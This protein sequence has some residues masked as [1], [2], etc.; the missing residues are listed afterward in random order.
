MCQNHPFMIASQLWHHKE[1]DMTRVS[2]NTVDKR[3]QVSDSDLRVVDVVL[4][5]AYVWINS[6]KTPMSMYNQTKFI[7]YAKILYP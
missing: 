2:I 4:R 7:T 3:W 6:M 1:Q 5:R